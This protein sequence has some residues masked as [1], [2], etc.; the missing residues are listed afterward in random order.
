[1]NYPPMLPGRRRRPDEEGTD[2]EQRM[3]E[4]SRGYEDSPC[5]PAGDTVRTASR[6]AIGHWGSQT[7]DSIGVRTSWL[8]GCRPS[9]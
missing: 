6:Q 5:L 7:R 8:R 4:L 3:Q 9:G 2:Q 1:M